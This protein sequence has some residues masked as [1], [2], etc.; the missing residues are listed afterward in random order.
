MGRWKPHALRMGYSSY[1]RPKASHLFETTDSVLETMERLQ[2]GVGPRLK[3]PLLLRDQEQGT[4]LLWD[5]LT[6]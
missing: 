4:K 3:L 1:L 6:V 5:Y 2:N